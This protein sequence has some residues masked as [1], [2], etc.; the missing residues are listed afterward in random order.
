MEVVDQMS[1]YETEQEQQQQ[2][3]TSHGDWHTRTV[4][5]EGALLLYDLRSLATQCLLCNWF[6]EYARHGERDQLAFSYI[7]HTQG[8]H[9]P[10][11]N[12]LPRKLHWS[13]MVSADTA[14]CYNATEDDA[15]QLAVR[16]QHGRGGAGGAAAAAAAARAR[17]RCAPAAGAY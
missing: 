15:A 14:A 3:V 4:V 16:F 6:N 17:G 8:P 9:A 2:Q 13:V 11:V 5:I 10:R 1:L 12:L 7:L